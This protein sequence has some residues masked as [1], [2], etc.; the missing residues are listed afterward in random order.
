[1]LKLEHAL[2]AVAESMMQKLFVEQV[3]IERSLNG[4]SQHFETVSEILSS[5]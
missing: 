4:R 1:M 5:R 3:D 2:S